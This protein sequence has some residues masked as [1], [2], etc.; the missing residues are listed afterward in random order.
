MRASALP[1]RKYYAEGNAYVVLEAGPGATDAAAWIADPTRGVGGDGLIVIEGSPGEAMHHMRVFN[2]DGGEA[3]WCGNGARAAAALICERDGLVE[4]DTVTIAAGGG[5]ALHVL[6]DR[7]RWR[8]RAEMPVPHDPIVE[9]GEGQRLVQTL[10]GAPHLVVFG[11]RPTGAE[12]DSAGAALCAARP[13]GTNVMFAERDGGGTLAV[14][15]W[16]RGVGPVSGCATGAAAAAIAAQRVLG[17]PLRAGTVVRQ[18]GGAIEVEW[19]PGERVLAM[20]GGARLTTAGTAVAP[21]GVGGRPLA[22]VPAGG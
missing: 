6:L 21:E 9:V 19:S 1:F 15:P 4:G 20:T 3:Q 16:E 10:I 18:P 12:V 5:I 7:A 14:T 17:Q 22:A 2:A 8:F 11:P 13:G